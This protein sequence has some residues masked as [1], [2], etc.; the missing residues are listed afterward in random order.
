M[1]AAARSFE[2]AD[3]L[4]GDGEH[5]LELPFHLAPDVVADRDGHLIHLRT[6]GCTVRL[7]IDPCL[8][9]RL[10]RGSES[11]IDGWFSAGY[12]RKVPSTTIRATAR[13]ALPVTMRTRIQI[14]PAGA[15]A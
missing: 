3:E 7:I 10:E 11:P 13:V 14:D 2:I 1:D 15:G 8:A 9:A 5:D 6:S 12:H 4:L